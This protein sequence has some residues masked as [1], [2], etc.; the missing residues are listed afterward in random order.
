MIARACRTARASSSGRSRGG[1]PKLEGRGFRRHVDQGFCGL[2]QPKFPAP[3]VDRAPEND[4]RNWFFSFVFHAIENEIPGASLGLRRRR[5]LIVLV[6]TFEVVES[7]ENNFLTVAPTDRAVGSR[8]DSLTLV[9]VEGDSRR[10]VG[11]GDGSM[12]AWTP[13]R[14][15]RPFSQAGHRLQTSSVHA[16][17]RRGVVRARR[18]FIFPAPPRVVSFVVASLGVVA[19]G[20][21]AAADHDA[22]DKHD[23]GGISVLGVDGKRYTVDEST[24]SYFRRDRGARGEGPRRAPEAVEERTI[25]AGNALEEAV[26]FEM[27]LSMDARCSRVMEKLLKA[28]T[29]DDLVRYLARVTKPPS[30]FFTMCKRLFGSRVAEFALG[31]V[32]RRESE[33]PRRVPPRD[34]RRSPSRRLRRHHRSR[35]GLRVR[36]ARLPRRAQI[37]L[38]PL[39]PRVF[40]VLQG[41]GIGG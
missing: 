12:A 41:C 34:A 19:G 35:G 32:A 36:P 22:R 30:D 8:A 23:Q 40:A 31:C 33:T 3:N 38:P 27:A 20:S 10:P 4:E 13:P 39:R 7:R 1:V 18:A 5:I 9:I 11:G 21:G 29:D 26:G 37:P 14:A 15:P 16:R 2:E 28:C 25:L 17:V 24:T 6:E